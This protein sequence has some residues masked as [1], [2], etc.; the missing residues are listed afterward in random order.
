M[1]RKEHWQR[2]MEIYF[3][4]EKRTRDPVKLREEMEKGAKELREEMSSYVK[5]KSEERDDYAKRFQEDVKKIR[6][7]MCEKHQAS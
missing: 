5:E 3:R 1:T 2:S 4:E 7:R 6:N